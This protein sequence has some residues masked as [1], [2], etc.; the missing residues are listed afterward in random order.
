MNNNI[1]I[2]KDIKD[3]KNIKDI[4]D[5]NDIKDIKDIKNTKDMSDIDKYIE[6]QIELKLNN[7]LETLPNTVPKDLYIKPIYNLT[8]KEI[9]KNTLQS[10]ID[11][12]NE[13]I[14]AYN[15]KDYI[16]T[17][18]YIYILINIFTKDNRKI[19]VGIMIVILSFIM[20]FIDSV[21]M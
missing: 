7:L 13:V 18:N 9:Y 8:I 14:D 11:I 1:N 19:Y 4:K 2:S 5:I 20:Y 6:E 12:I 3:I 10:L 16:N 21:S 15:K 17:N